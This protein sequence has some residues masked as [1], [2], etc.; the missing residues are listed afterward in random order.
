MPPHGPK[1]GPTARR[2]ATQTETQPEDQL[3]QPLRVKPKR[4][5]DKRDSHQAK[6]KKEE[7]G[8]ERWRHS[9]NPRSCTAVV[10]KTGQRPPVG[11]RYLS[12]EDGDDDLTLQS[13]FS[14]DARGPPDAQVRL[15]AKPGLVIRVLPVDE[16]K[17]NG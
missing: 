12:P 7:V 11:A 8:G 6:P 15:V 4:P 17:A 5:T 3:R 9:C 2:A 13:L 1:K 16:R 14:W 10:E